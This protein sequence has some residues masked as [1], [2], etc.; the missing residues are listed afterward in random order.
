MKKLYICLNNTVYS[1][2]FH[3]NSY[4]DDW[5]GCIIFI[6]K[7][8]Y[9]SYNSSRAWKDWRADLGER[10]NVTYTS[11]N[12]LHSRQSCRREVPHSLILSPGM[13]QG[14]QGN[15]CGRGGGQRGL[16]CLGMLL[17]SVAGTLGQRTP[18][19]HSSLESNNHKALSYQWPAEVG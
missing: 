4:Q 9:Y 18:K 6:F 13:W 7:Y 16:T 15:S 17:N 14:G 1:P 11:F 12:R 8:K 5:E 19:V 10:Y 3:K 2:S